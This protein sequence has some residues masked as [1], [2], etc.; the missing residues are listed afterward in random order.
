MRAVSDEVWRR[1]NPNT[2][3]L[4]R[5]STVRLWVA[6]LVAVTVFVGGTAAT[7][8][9]AFT[10]RLVWS[11]NPPASGW[12]EGSD[13]FWAKVLFFNFG[14][15]AVTVLDVGR[16]SPGLE[17]LRASAEHTLPM[18][19]RP[20]NSVWV[21]LTYRVT[22]CAAVLADEPSPVAVV[23]RPWGPQTLQV[24]AA[25]PGHPWYW[26]SLDEICRR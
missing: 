23:D 6:L 18:T 8:L 17:L 9:G 15:S 25:S 26:P 10:P 2:G 24:G 4:S 20:G 13:E 1:L 11:P 16:P 21:H 22:D 7:G 12:F 5:A 19:L 14:Q 3:R